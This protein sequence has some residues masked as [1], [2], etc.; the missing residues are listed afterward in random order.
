MGLFLGPIISGAIAERTSWRWFF[1]ACTIAQAVNFACLV[2]LSPETRR[3]LYDPPELS[4]ESTSAQVQEQTCSADISEKEHQE[5]RIEDR[6]NGDIDENGTSS[7]HLDRGR[8]SIGQ[9]NVFQ[10]VDR[11]AL[12]TIIHH[13]ITPL[14]IF[15]FPIVLWAAM[16]MGA[17]A[18]ALLCVNLLQ[19]Q[20]LAAPPY[21]FTQIGRAH[22]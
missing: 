19:S 21:N 20:A 10:A 15:F 1:W 13:F 14:E 12:R 6:A 7:R 5:R 18:N 3:L 16:S 2:C 17:A 8:P 9:F 11:R 4:L 22:V